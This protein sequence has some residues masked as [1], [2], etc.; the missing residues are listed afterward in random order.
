MYDYWLINVVIG[1]ICLRKKTGIKSCPD[2]KTF[3]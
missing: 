1:Q 2:I 3:K